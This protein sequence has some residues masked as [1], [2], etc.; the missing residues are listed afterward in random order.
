[1]ADQ[2]RVLR[3]ASDFFYVFANGRLVTCKARGKIKSRA[4]H[5]DI[6]AIGDFVTF[7]PLPDGSGMITDVL[8]RT[9]EWVRMMTGTKVPY[10]QVLIANRNLFLHIGYNL[11]DFKNPN[12]LMLG[13]GFRF[14]SV[15]PKLF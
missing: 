5:T 6:I 4:Q 15:K 2:G 10:R 11:Q 8:P 3:F 13:F 9:S 14:H 12:Y 7:E 1:M